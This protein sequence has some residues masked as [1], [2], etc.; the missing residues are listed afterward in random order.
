MLGT[1]KIDFRVYKGV[2][3]IPVSKEIANNL[4]SQIEKTSFDPWGEEFSGLVAPTGDNP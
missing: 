1:I 2:L 3:L 4:L